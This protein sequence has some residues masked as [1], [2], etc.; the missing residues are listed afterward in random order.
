MG[1]RAGIKRK[2]P[3][4]AIFL[5]IFLG[6]ALRLFVWQNCSIVNPDAISYIHQAKALYY[7][8]W[9]ELT[10]CGL[11]HLSIYPPLITAAHH[12]TNDWVVAARIISLVF[13]L[14]MLTVLYNLLR[15]FFDEEISMLVLLLFTLI[16]IFVKGSIQIIRDPEFWFLYVLGL[17]FLFRQREKTLALDTVWSGLCFS[18]AIWCRIEAVFILIMS[19]F[20]VFFS[21]K[22][23][24]FLWLFLFFMPLALILSGLLL[25]ATAHGISLKNIHRVNEIF[26]RAAFPLHQYRYLETILLQMIKETPQGIVSH[27]LSEA[28][29][30]IWLVGLGTLVNRLCEG[31][32]Y[33]YILVALAGLAGIGKEIRKDM[34]IPFLL[35]LTVF[36][37]FFLYFHILFVWRISYRNMAVII[38]PCA[39]LT[40]FGFRN[41]LNFLNTRAPFQKSGAV[42]FL[43]ALVL[44]FGLARNLMPE[45]QNMAVFKEI[46]QLIEKE[47]RGKGP[48]TVSSCSRSPG[49]VSFYA[50]L[51]YPGT[52]CGNQQAYQWKEIERDPRTFYE[53]LTDEG[54]RYFL[55]EET[56]CSKEAL[57]ALLET[58]SGRF[59]KRGEWHHPTT[60]QMILY[61][62]VGLRNENQALDPARTD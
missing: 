25:W 1:F 10:R 58:E 23:R 56:C 43:A 18:L 15:L 39:V 12:I 28:R 45:K 5:I 59:K 61:E 42:W 11:S 26:V 41:S 52:Y 36:A 50:N 17:Y 8:Q 24:R 27:F 2:P 62:R 32:F 38:I 22:H 3:A 55:W 19:A 29:N 40:G 9:H 57:R 6:L 44:L 60:G 48:V 47:D 54:I 13:G 7:G 49:W 14:A 34:R 16:P 30:T 37:I 21:R 4:L 33:P 35:T 46:G 51:N 53:R 20:Y 31:F